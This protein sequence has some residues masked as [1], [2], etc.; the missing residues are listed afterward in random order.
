LKTGDVAIFDEFYD[1]TNEFRALEDYRAAQPLSTRIRPATIIKSPY[2]TR[3]RL[4]VTP[5]NG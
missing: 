2:P 3:K 4:V 1:Y 5:A